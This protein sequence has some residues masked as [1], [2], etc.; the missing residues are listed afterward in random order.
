[1]ASINVTM[2]FRD[3]KRAGRQTRSFSVPPGQ[4]IWK[5]KKAVPLTTEKLCEVVMEYL[6]S[7]GVVLLQ[8]AP[9]RGASPYGL[10][11]KS[12]RRAK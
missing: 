1:M 2:T 12:A 11:P 8:N 3:P 9:T 5:G 7:E 4:T 10:L 6:K